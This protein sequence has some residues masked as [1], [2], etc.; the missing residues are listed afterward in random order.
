MRF[1]CFSPCE[2]RNQNVLFASL[3]HRYL[4]D[5][6][7]SRLERFVN[8]TK[9]RR[10]FLLLFFLSIVKRIHSSQEIG[11]HRAAPFIAKSKVLLAQRHR[12]VS[13][14]IKRERKTHAHEEDRCHLNHAARQKRHCQAGQRIKK[15]PNS[16]TDERERNWLA[17]FYGFSC[18]ANA[19]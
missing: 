14:A 18:I 16:R 4:F 9:R 19:H 8:E 13:D 5:A 11:N 6:S 7:S 17:I 2:M 3:C 12:R 15:T 10:H 1:V